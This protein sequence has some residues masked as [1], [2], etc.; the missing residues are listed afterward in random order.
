MAVLHK[1]LR[2]RAAFAILVAL[3]ALNILGNFRQS[4]WQNPDKEFQV[5]QVQANIGNVEKIYA[6][7]GLA[8]QQTIADRYFQ[9][10]QQG[11]AANP[12]ANLVVWPES[13]F[14]D[15]LNEHH[16]NST[17]P[18]QFFNFVRQIKTP[19][20]TGA[21]SEDPP[22]VAKP[23]QY[24]ALFLFNANGENLGQ[25]KK[26]HLLIFGEYTPLSET[27]P[28]IAKISPAGSGFGRGS[29][30]I[31][32]PLEQIQLGPQIC[33]ESLDPDFSAAQTRKGAHILVNL[34]NDSWFGP[35]FEPE[36]HMLM[37]L[38]RALENRRPMIRSTNTGITT[39]ILADGE[40]LQSS[41]LYQS[42]FGN[43]KIKFYAQPGLTF[44]TQFEAWLGPLILLA[45]L[46]ILGGG[47]RRAKSS[48]P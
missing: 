33:Y 12:G 34:T 10:T 42:W 43:F 28:I 47:Y 11:L 24:N 14:P 9:L 39:A 37:T 18:M 8:Y 20:L 41:P 26:T 7:K 5:L 30:A 22:Q 19:I 21:Y 48:A 27:F 38:A 46:L 36:Q 35:R 15:F 25:Y 13:A 23:A 3:L 40:Q 2:I 32:L 31:T 44:Y 6:E 4:L 16:R 45:L 17:Y 29:G 1:N